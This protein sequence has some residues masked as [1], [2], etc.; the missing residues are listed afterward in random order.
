MP[1]TIEN[2]P[3]AVPFPGLDGSA[4]AC[5]LRSGETIRTTL[6]TISG[7]ALAMADHALPPA[8]VAARATDGRSAVEQTLAWAEPPERIE[9]STTGLSFIGGRPATLQIS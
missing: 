6:F 4:F 3:V 2:L 7:T 9:S 5:R 8:V 1:W